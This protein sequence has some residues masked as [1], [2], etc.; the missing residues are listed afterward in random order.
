MT[1]LS[2]TFGTISEMN[3]FL[4]V[5]EGIKV[6]NV[7]TVVTRRR[8]GAFTEPRDIESFRLWYTDKK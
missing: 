4:S 2:K 3:F 6:V 7:E 8:L 5:T 1:L